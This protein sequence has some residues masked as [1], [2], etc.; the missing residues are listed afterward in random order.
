[1]IASEDITSSRLPCLQVTTVVCITPPLDCLVTRGVG[2]TMPHCAL[3]VAKHSLEGCTVSRSRI[4]SE[5]AEHVDCLCNIRPSA[6]HEV[7][8]AA[9]NSEIFA[10]VF[11]GRLF[12]YWGCVELLIRIHGKESGNRVC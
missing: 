5:S 2:D 6:V 8:M 1:M 11:R 4:L 7:K 10:F 12:S 3:E 9:H